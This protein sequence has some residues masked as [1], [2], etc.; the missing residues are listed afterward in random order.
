MNLYKYSIDNYGNVNISIYE[1]VKESGNYYLVNR[2]EGAR[3]CELYNVK[4]SSMNE[5]TKDNVMYSLSNV[6]VEL[7][8]RLLIKKYKKKI[9]TCAKAINKRLQYEIE[10]AKVVEE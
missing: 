3:L 4:K 7:Y 2:F 10:L 8:R 5:I 6:K 1:I 9:D